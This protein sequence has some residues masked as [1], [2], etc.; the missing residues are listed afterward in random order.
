MKTTHPENVPGD[1]TWAR[2]PGTGGDRF[3]MLRPSSD[4]YELMAY[5]GARLE[6][7]ELRGP[8]LVANLPSA[9]ACPKCLRLAKG[10]AA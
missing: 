8:P 1:H 4:A 7:G 6:A 5:C 9:I 2:L 3:H 10:G